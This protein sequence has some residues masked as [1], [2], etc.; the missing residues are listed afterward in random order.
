MPS[1]GVYGEKKE[2]RLS[3]AQAV[4]MELAGAV[5]DADCRK[6]FVQDGVSSE[7]G[8]CN[9]FQPEAPDTK[10]FR[11]GDCEYLKKEE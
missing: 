11:C 1:Y 6:V 8:C 2:S 10:R 9:E 3:A 5:K 4:Y 7:L